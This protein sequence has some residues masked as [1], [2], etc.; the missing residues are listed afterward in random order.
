MAKEALIALTQE[1]YRDFINMRATVRGIRGQGVN[2]QWGAGI[3]I[4]PPQRSQPNI[5]PQAKPPMRVKIGTAADSNGVVVV[6]VVDSS[7][8]VVTGATNISALAATR[9]GKVGDLIFIE[10]AT[11]NLGVNDSSSNPVVWIEVAIANTASATTIN[12]ETD[13]ADTT[14]WSRQSNATPLT[15]RRYRYNVDGTSFLLNEFWRDESY[16]SQGRLIS[17]TAET[18]NTIDTGSGCP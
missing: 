4:N 6:Q 7:G 12:P 17:V 9:K 16:D 11:P 3:T 18:L 15:I 1:E 5:L 8:T 2:I 13:S 14:T 10:Q